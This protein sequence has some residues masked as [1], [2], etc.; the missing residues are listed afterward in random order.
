MGGEGGQEREAEYTMMGGVERYR[1]GEERKVDIR[2]RDGEEWVGGWEMTRG[3]GGGLW[4]GLKGVVGG[5]GEEGGGLVT[6]KGE[7]GKK[8]ESKEQEER[9]KNRNE[10]GGG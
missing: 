4:G 3:V 1:G 8:G 10:K 6:G 2:S 7:N 5:K 9:T